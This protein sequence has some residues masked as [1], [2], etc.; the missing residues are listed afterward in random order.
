MPAAI[1]LL[2]LAAAIYAADRLGRHTLEG[3]RPHVH[4]T[5]PV[6]APQALRE[7]EPLLQEIL[8]W[9]T[10]SDWT[11]S[12]SQRSGLP[13][14]SEVG[15]LR[16]PFPVENT[17]CALWSGGLDALAG[18]YERASADD[19]RRFLLIGTGANTQALGRQQDVFAGL[20]AVLLRRVSLV[21]I[22]I[23]PR[24]TGRMRSN[25][26]ARARGLVHML[27]GS[28]VAVLLSG[29]GGLSVYENGVGAL[30][31]PYSKA[32]VGL[33][34]SR[35]VHPLTLNLVSEF[36]SEVLRRPFEISNPFLFQTKAQMLGGLAD[37]GQCDLIFRT[38]SCD[39]PRRK[40]SVQCGECSSCVLRRQSIAA[41]GLEDLTGYVSDCATRSEMDSRFAQAASRQAGVIE[42]CI[43]GDA[44]S[45]WERLTREYP[46]LDDVVDR[47]AGQAPAGMRAGFVA[48]FRR[49]VADWRA[50]WPAFESVGLLPRPEPRAA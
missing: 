43:G 26:L 23:H 8:D 42:A 3:V 25:G 10:G 1:D 7:H 14:K 28:A 18:L 35:S 15:P 13:R 37:D 6:R 27:V 49:H 9:L 2:D 41:A 36:V 20:H 32:Q 29:A 24:G 11:F 16:I 38:S 33:D 40:R 44:D 50:A 5:L 22:P 21:R 12:F 45:S 47:L 19:A 39:S 48:L 46:D 17:E 30:N 34:H 4:L 31:L